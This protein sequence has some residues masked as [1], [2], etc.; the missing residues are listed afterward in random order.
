V[1]AGFLELQVIS[2]MDF[3]SLVDS[4]INNLKA[5]GNISMDFPFLV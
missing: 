3:L 5:S 2:S 1:I 4:E